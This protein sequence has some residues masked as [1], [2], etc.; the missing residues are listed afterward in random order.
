MS[1]YT[2]TTEAIRRGYSRTG[3]LSQQRKEAFDRWL[4]EHDRLVVWNYWR[5]KFNITLEGE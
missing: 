2:P 5:E 1:D 3:S 4:A